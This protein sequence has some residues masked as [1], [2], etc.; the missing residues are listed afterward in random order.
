MKHKTIKK[1]Q[2][3]YI[4]CSSTCIIFSIILALIVT[5]EQAKVL[6]I[7]NATLATFGLLITV[8]AYLF[9]QME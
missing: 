4:V 5:P 3:I 1:I 7:T 2:Y 6:M 9:K 8:V